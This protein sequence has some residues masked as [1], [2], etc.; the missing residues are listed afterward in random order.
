MT[1]LNPI[2]DTEFYLFDGFYPQLHNRDIAEEE[3]ESILKSS[4]DENAADALNLMKLKLKINEEKLRGYLQ[5]KNYLIYDPLI[6]G[7]GLFTELYKISHL[8]DGDFKGKDLIDFINKFGLPLGE[9]YFNDKPDR[10][11][12]YEMGVYHFY[13]ELME[14]KYI[15][16]LWLSDQDQLLH[17]K[18]ITK[19]SGGSTVR[20]TNKKYV[21]THVFQ[22][23][24]DVAYFQLKNAI[25]NEVNLKN[26]EHCGH[27][28]P[29]THES[30]KYCSSL[31]GK[32]ESTCLNVYK[33]RLKRQKAKA[34]KLHREG[35]SLLEIQ[36]TINAKIK[37]N[38]K[39]KSLDDI[40]KWIRE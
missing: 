2:S 33:Q 34:K 4:N 7:E 12:L 5:N 14:Y 9:N 13:K 11:L 24:F 28:F 18:L 38:S 36:K 1:L 15:F 29:I 10:V 30:R 20:R 31:P 26:C 37:D 32:K 27:L 22:N 16:N 35:M 19:S 3:F 39:I 40:K 17:D 23:L 8:W 21:S 6:E 25:V